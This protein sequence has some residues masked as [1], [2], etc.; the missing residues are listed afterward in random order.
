MVAIA[1]RLAIEEMQSRKQ[2]SQSTREEL[3]AVV[4]I[5][6]LAIAAKYGSPPNSVTLTEKGI[7]VDRRSVGQSHQGR[8]LKRAYPK[9]RG[10][11]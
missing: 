10:L 2:H 5:E 11:Q 8:R 6:A 3:D 1:A 4:Q 7:F 9:A